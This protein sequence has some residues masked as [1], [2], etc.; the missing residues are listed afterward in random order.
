MKLG[1][2]LCGEPQQIQGGIEIPVDDQPTDQTLIGSVF[3]RHAFFDMPTAG[4]AFGR[5]K[6]TRSDEEI[7][8]SVGYLRLQELQKLS[9]RS[10]SHSPGQLSIG[11]HSQD[12]Q[13]FDA[14]DSAGACQFGGELVLDIPTDVGDLLVLA[15]HLQSLLLVVATEKG[16]LGFRIFRFLFPTKHSL[17]L[18][19]L[20]EMER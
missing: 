9:H 11:H 3:E 16:S 10:I 6:P 19:E 17:Q 13:V 8:P 20:F 2:L 18:A 1:K 12:I 14:K 15:R 7:S 4:A 5:R